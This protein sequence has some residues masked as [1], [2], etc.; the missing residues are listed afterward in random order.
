MT[1][2]WLPTRNGRS[3]DHV[4]A[5]LSRGTAL[6]RPLRAGETEP[7][8]SVFESMSP[9]S[10]L[11]R[12]LVGVP[13][14]PSTM[15]AALADVDGHDHVAWLATVEGAPAGIARSI[16][17]APDTAEIAFEVAD[18][19]QG[20]GLGTVLLDTVTTL[21]A[22]HG[23]RRVQATVMPTNAPSLRLLARLGIPLTLSD[24]LLEGEGPLRLLDPPRVDR[25]AVVALA[26]RHA[27]QTGPE[28]SCA[29]PGPSAH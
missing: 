3:L 24:G 20:R 22:T 16:R 6:L 13:R 29:V 9:S 26:A 28:G 27:E 19:H 7:L 18:A 1:I 23:V 5:P 15:L 25:R 2:S 14:L 12:Y 8:L 4:V 21:A 17:V 10:R 11:D